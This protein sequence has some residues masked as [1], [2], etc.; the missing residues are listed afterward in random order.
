MNKQDL[1]SKIKQLDGISQ[2]ERA[3]LINLVNT[4]KKYGLVWEDKPE[5]FEEQLRDNL[6]VL[7]E[8]KEKA[9]ING[10]DNPNHI[11]IEGDNLHALTAL[12]FTHEGKIDVIYI[13]PP[14]NTGNKDFVYNDTFV[15]FEDSFRHSKWLSFMYK[16]LQNAKRLLNENG[17]IFISIDDNEV[18]QLKLLCN[19][20]FGENNFITQ[21]L[22]EKT[23]TPPALSKKVR[24][25]ME[26]ILCYEKSRDNSSYSIGKVDGGDVPL[27]NSGNATG[28]LHFPVGSIKFNIPDGIYTDNPERKVRIIS[29][30]LIVKDSL[31]TNAVIL[32]G[33]FKWKQEMLEKEII[34]G[35]HFIIKTELFSIRF[36]RREDNLKT[37]TPTNRL[38]KE[39]NVG[40]NEDAKKEIDELS[41]NYFDYPKPVSLIKIL[42]NLKYKQDSL[43]LDFFAGSG[44][45]LHATMALNSE[46]GGNRQCILVTNNENN[47]C[48]E[49][50]YERNKRVIQGYTNAK[51]V[52]VEGLKNNN[53]RYYKSEF[54]SRDTS[55]KNKREL[56]FL[57]TELLCIKED[58]YTA[59]PSKEKWFKAF[60]SKTAQFI[61]I[62]DEVRIEDSFE[63]IEA[64]HTQKTNDNPVKVYVFSHGQYPFTE[65][66]EEVLPLITLCALPDAIYKAYQNVLP[67]KKREV[68][69]VLEEDAVGEEE[70]LF[71]QDAH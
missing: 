69:P 59:F 61:V 7:K 26:Y 41:I 38:D 71:N 57:A 13:D 32:E 42:A 40:T 68:V 60:T 12:T 35:T 30:Q 54:V 44:T 58:C 18:A 53:L 5:D 21:F 56:T 37:K 16:R 39:L 6:P 48:E 14:Y 28:Q 19:D 55:L 33:N 34:L 36:Q 49:V 24:K 27:L 64:L 66:F 11:L 4:K 22:W 62:Y 50:T 65:D 17:V 52:A 43:I 63:I 25:K 45:T 67:K 23:S 46:D 2:D 29:D 15:D 8:V 51:G 3:Y 1:I 9:I 20:V 47:I 10:E 31:N 70:N